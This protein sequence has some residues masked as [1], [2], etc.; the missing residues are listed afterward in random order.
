MCLGRT[1][2]G[3]NPRVV[4]GTLSCPSG[5]VTADVTVTGQ[6]IREMMTARRNRLPK[7]IVQVGDRPVGI[8]A[9]GAKAPTR[10]PPDCD[11]P[12]VRHQGPM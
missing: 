4:P 10:L 2:L 12:P 5:G 3:L 6:P 8:Q 11:T 9:E 1:Q 7:L